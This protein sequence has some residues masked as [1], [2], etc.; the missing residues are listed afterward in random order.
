M[1]YLNGFFQIFYPVFLVVIAV[2]PGFITIANTSMNYGFKKGMVAVFGGWC[3]DITYITI[4]AFAIKIILDS[5]S[6]NFISYMSLFAS[7]FLLYISYSFWKIDVNK[8][9]SFNLK[10]NSISI[11]TKMLILG[12]SSP[13][14]IVG[15]SAIFSTVSNDNTLMLPKLLGGYCAALFGHSCVVILFSTIGKKINNN[16]LIIL[17]KISA[18]LIACFAFMLIFNF[19]KYLFK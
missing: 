3:V 16:I 13:I 1:S 2:G 5:L 18:F 11:F 4:G 9:K 7:A 15:Y 10:K 6:E 14:A 8:I 19:I 12:F 17:N